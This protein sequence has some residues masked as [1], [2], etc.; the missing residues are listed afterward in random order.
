LAASVVGSP[1]SS[2]NFSHVAA[3]I[4]ESSYFTAQASLGTGQSGA[5]QAGAGLADLAILFSIL[6]LFSWSCL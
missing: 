1:D 5:P 3:Q 6:F 2:V 4:P